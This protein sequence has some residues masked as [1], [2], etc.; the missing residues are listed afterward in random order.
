[1]WQIR[2]CVRALAADRTSLVAQWIGTDGLSLADHLLYHVLDALQIAN[3]QRT[4]KRSGRPK[5]LSPMR[6]GKGSSGSNTY[7]GT[8]RSNAEVIDLL[9]RT[10]GR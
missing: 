7:G 4:G 8:D 3:W 1:M 5:P 6:D 10:T 9:A 2:A